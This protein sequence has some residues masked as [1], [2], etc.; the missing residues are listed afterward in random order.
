MI[1]KFLIL[2]A[3][4]L[5]FLSNSEII[6]NLIISYIN[7]LIIIIDLNLTGLTVIFSNT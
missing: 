3:V 1:N 2:N 7:N 6:I 5:S 4:I